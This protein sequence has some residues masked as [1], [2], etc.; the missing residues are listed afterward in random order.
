MEQSQC[1]DSFYRSR[2]LPSGQAMMMMWIARVHSSSVRRETTDINRPSF[3]QDTSRRKCLRDERE[4]CVCPCVNDVTIDIVMTL[5]LLEAFWGIDIQIK[6]EER[7]SHHRQKTDSVVQYTVG[8]KKW[9][10]CPPN[11]REV[12]PYRKSTRNLYLQ[13]PSQPHPNAP[14]EWCHP[15]RRQQYWAHKGWNDVNAFPPSNEET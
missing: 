4:S 2:T 10:P 3:L 14:S 6:G 8:S 15:L 5:L 9:D 11:W 7:P 1:S 13:M 12:D